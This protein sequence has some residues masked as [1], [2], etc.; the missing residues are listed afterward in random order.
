MCFGSRDKTD[1]GGTRSRELD[2]M[3]RQDEK[4]MSKEVKLLLLGTLNSAC[5][6]SPLWPMLRFPCP[7]LA[8]QQ[9][10]SRQYRTDRCIQGLES[11]ANRQSSSR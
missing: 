7:Q 5:P 11:P 3:I 1:N 6:S 9:L 8:P 4:R 10:R 2:K